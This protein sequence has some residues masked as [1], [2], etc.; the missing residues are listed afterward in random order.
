MKPM[1][2]YAPNAKNFKITHSCALINAHFKI[3]KAHVANASFTVT[4]LT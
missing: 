4:D 1:E 2:N 3:K